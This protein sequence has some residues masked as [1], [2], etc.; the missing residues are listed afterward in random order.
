MKKDFYENA[1]ENALMLAASLRREHRRLVFAR[2]LVFPAAGAALIHGYDRGA[3]GEMLLGLFLVVLFAVLVA[4]HAR[5]ERR[6]R[7]MEAYLSVVAGYLARFAG[8]WKSEP[9]TG[10]Q[11]RKAKRPPDA[12]LHI[13]GTASLYQYLCC[14]R[15]LAGRD[16]LARALTATPRD[17]MRTRR[18]QAAV[19][20][21]L[22]HPLLCLELTA[23]GVRLPDGHAAGLHLAPPILRGGG[24][25]LARGICGAAVGAARRRD[26]G[27]AAHDM[28][29]QYGARARLLPAHTARA[30]AARTDGAGAAALREYLSC[31]RACT[32]ARG[33]PA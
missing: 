19:A 33:C 13:F 6:R 8:T 18:R 12:D 24:G 2:T 32:A 15:T 20:E 7:F 21:L 11:Y 5:L 14:A 16:R 1:W 26:V 30:R 25:I 4:R 31:A 10:A 22:A 9:V 28:V 27:T 23:R 29:A 3:A 17:L